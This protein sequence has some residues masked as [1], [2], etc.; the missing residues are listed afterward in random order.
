MHPA[1]RWFWIVTMI[2]SAVIAAA[3]AI[4]FEK[5]AYR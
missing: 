1:E 4:L 5:G 2:C 3:I